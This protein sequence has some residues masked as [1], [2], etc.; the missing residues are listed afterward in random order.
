LDAIAVTGRIVGAAFANEI[1]GDGN[2]IAGAA[3]VTAG[4]GAELAM[5]DGEVTAGLAGSTAAG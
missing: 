5:V 2:D 1:V 4:L 3:G